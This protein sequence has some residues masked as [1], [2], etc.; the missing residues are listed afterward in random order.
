MASRFEFIRSAAPSR[1]YAVTGLSLLWLL[2]AVCVIRAL[3]GAFSVAISSPEYALCIVLASLCGCGL[4]LAAEQPPFRLSRAD[5]VLFGNLSLF[6]ILAIAATLL[7]PAW[8]A[9]GVAGTAVWLGLVGWFCI[10]TVAV[11]WL[12][13][14]CGEIIWPEVERF[15]CPQSEPGGNRSDD[16]PFRTVPRESLISLAREPVLNDQPDDEEAAGDLISRWQRR[17]GDGGS[18]VL[19]GQLVATFESGSRHAVLHVPFSP[20]FSAAPR[21]DCEVT[22]GSEV[23]IKVGAVFT[24]GVRLELKRNSTELPN[25]DVALEIYAELAASDDPVTVALS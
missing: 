14:T 6:P 13:W 19:E 8:S 7:S 9:L 16:S 3:C 25:L 4:K 18:D 23:R 20:P 11:E 15:L 5:S 10:S 1:L 12:R 2:S 24:Y 17:S 21:V 22:D